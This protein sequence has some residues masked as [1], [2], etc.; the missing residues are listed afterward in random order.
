MKRT[1]VFL[2]AFAVIG[3]IVS[4]S[5]NA[6]PATWDAI[7]SEAPVTVTG[8]NFQQTF[9]FELLS[10]FGD[11]TEGIIR[12]QLEGE[13][14]ML[15]FDNGDSVSSTQIEGLFGPSTLIVVSEP[16]TFI[17]FGLGLLGM[18]CVV[19]KRRS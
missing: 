9:G 19:R 2:I 8:V 14:Q 13:S 5:A 1:A 16:A 6:L 7:I 17:L 15:N 10:I 11:D 18:A 4:G 12:F 3:L